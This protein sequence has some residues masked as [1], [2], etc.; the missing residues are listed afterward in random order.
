MGQSDKKLDPKDMQV[1]LTGRV[2]DYQ[3]LF[4]LPGGSYWSLRSG[5]LAAASVG[6]GHTYRYPT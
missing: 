6:L 3:T 1:Y 2:F 5:T 4:R